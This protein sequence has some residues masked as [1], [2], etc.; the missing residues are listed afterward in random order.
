[1]Y[2]SHN[3]AYDHIHQHSIYIYKYINNTY[4]WQL[5]LF[6]QLY[7]FLHQK[8]Y[9]IKELIQ[10]LYIYICICITKEAIKFQT[11]KEPPHPSFKLLH[12]QCCKVPKLAI[13]HFSHFLELG[14]LH[15]APLYSFFR[16]GKP[17][18]FFF[19][20]FQDAIHTFTVT[21]R[22]ITSLLLL[23]FSISKHKNS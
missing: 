15:Y 6:N 20:L 23:T 5:I 11:T 14:F 18:F 17:C 13:S 19:L 4:L 1:M 2:F 8:I 7:K 22:R 12:F 9:K 21:D 10:I 3:T 16:I